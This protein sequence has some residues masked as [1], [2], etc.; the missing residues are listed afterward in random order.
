MN[1][2]LLRA[3]TISMADWLGKGKAA[4]LDQST[5]ADGQ[6]VLAKKSTRLCLPCR[7]VCGS[8]P[9][10]GGILLAAAWAGRRQTAVPSCAYGRSTGAAL[11][12]SGTWCNIAEGW[13]PHPLR[14][15]SARHIVK[16]LPHTETKQGKGYFP[17]EGLFP[18]SQKKKNPNP[19][20][21]FTIHSGKWRANSWLG[22][23]QPSPV[24]FCALSSL[25]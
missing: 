13:F 21:G 16:G 9:S 19:F 12:E 24:H 5:A 7:V 6:M 25:G 8:R 22:P 23:S 14:P 15:T 2:E 17:E 4:R 11:P 18:P 10:A 1:W 3:F 20:V